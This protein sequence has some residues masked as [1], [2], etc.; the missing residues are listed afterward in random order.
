MESPKFLTNLPPRPRLKRVAVLGGLAL[1]AAFAARQGHP[2]SGPWQDRLLSWGGALLF[3]VLA[4]AAGIKLGDELRRVLLPS[5]GDAR[6]AIVRL[7]AALSVGLSA[8][9]MTLALLRL[10]IGQLLL[11]GALTGAVLGIAGQQTLANVFAGI[12]L[13]YARPFAIGDA[14][15]IRS[16]P[17]GG[18]LEGTVEEIGLLYVSLSGEEGC[19]SVPNSLMQSAAVAKVPGVGSG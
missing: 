12:V 9:I 18:S 16:G 4:T 1:V 10:P 8:L 2:A 3:L 5:L 15:T 11:G 17:L 6:A 7:A 14:V 13:L 19:F